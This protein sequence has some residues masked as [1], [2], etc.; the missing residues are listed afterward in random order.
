MVFMNI[1]A[2][3]KQELF[4]EHKLVWSSE[5]C[6]V[7]RD[8]SSLLE[9]FHGLTNGAL[10]EKLTVCGDVCKNAYD[11]LGLVKGFQAAQNTPSGKMK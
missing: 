6:S 8:I 7:F 3:G 11:A 5:Y 4:L 9:L 10:A 1:I 2:L